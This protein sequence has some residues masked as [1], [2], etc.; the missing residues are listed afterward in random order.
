MAEQSDTTNPSSSLPRVVP[1][2]G[3][4]GCC[5]TLRLNGHEVLVDAGNKGKPG[6]V[7]VLW[8]KKKCPVIVRRLART[9]PYPGEA[10]GPAG[11][12]MLSDRFYYAVPGVESSH[13]EAFGVRWR[14]LPLRDLGGHGASLRHAGLP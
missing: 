11:V 7:V 12:A 9:S 3:P 5:Y 6:D 2:S 4:S 14:H 10:V 8:P 13:E 1:L